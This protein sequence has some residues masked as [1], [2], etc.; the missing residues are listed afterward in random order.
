LCL[1]THGI[2][3]TPQGGQ[4]LKNFAVGICGAQQ[5]WTMSEFIGREIIRIRNLVGPTGQVLG[6]VSGGVDSTVAAKLL[7]EAIGDRF[8]GMQPFPSHQHQPQLTH[9]SRPCGQW[10]Y[11]SERVRNR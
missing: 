6:A 7:T 9:G 2:S 10:M 3:D 4:L 5:T 8:H 1:G 11:A